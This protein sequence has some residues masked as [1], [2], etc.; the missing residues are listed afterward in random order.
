MDIG[1]PPIR[2]SPR[3]STTGPAHRPAPPSTRCSSSSRN[4]WADEPAG[5]GLAGARSGG[6]AVRPADLHRR[7]PGAGH[8]APPAVAG[9]PRL[10]H[11]VLRLP[12]GGGRVGCPPQGA[13]VRH[14]SLI[15]IS[16]P[17]RPY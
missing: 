5:R 11:L 3:T 9:P 4:A 1:R 12:P 10:P 13:P 17:T 7:P 14:L 2:C 8:L 6:E 16:E 15:H